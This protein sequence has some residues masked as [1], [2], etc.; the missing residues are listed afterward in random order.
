[1]SVFDP[2]GDYA[3]V[4]FLETVTYFDKLSHVAF[5]SGT[6]V[7]S[8]LREVLSGVD[9]RQLSG[10]EQ[11]WHIWTENMGSIA[12]KIGDVIRDSDGVRW[13][14]V[15]KELRTAQTRWQFSVER[16]KS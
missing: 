3:V 14:I 1:M 10:I 15:H 6:T 9:P 8:A 5:G 12:P 16:E 11:V 7:T 2:G 13:T 4:D